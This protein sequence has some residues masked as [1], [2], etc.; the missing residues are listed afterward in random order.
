MVHSPKEVNR[1]ETLVQK[2]EKRKTDRETMEKRELARFSAE[3][4]E[5][6]TPVEKKQR[7]DNGLKSRRK[8]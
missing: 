8:A 1:K 7:S 4:S 3:A 6:A 5:P 2:T